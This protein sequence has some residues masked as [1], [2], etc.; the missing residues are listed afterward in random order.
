M[1][2]VLKP[3]QLISFDSSKSNSWFTQDFKSPLRQLH[4]STLP[5][6]II[7]LELLLSLANIVL[8]NRT[9]LIEFYSIKTVGLKLDPPLTHV[10]KVFGFGLNLLKILMIQIPNIW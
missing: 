7:M 10:P 3:M 2:K 9:F 1:T 6:K 8:E 4:G 5:L